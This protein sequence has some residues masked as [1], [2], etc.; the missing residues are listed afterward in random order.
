MV[1]DQRLLDELAE[2][3]GVR[4]P[5]LD[6][7]APEPGAVLGAPADEDTEPADDDDDEP[8]DDEAETVARLRLLQ[9]GEP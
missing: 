3:Y 2:R 6:T 4:A 5:T 1:V 8:A 9:R 7:S